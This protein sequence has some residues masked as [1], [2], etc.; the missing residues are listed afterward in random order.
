MGSKS[1][2][3]LPLVAVLGCCVASCGGGNSSSPAPT[4]TVGGTVTGLLSGTSVTLQN[5]AANDTPVSVNASF[6]FSNALAGGTMY[7]VTVLTQP[8]GETCTIAN[9]TGVIA[10]ANVSVAV[11]CVPNNYSVGGTVSGL[12]P[13]VSVTLVNNGGNS[14]TVTANGAFRFST[15]VAAG[16]AYSVSVWADPSGESCTVANG[17]GTV[18][19]ANITGITVSCSVL[20]YTINA[21]V[22]GLVANSNLVLQ[23]NGGDTLTVTSGGSFPFKAAIPS[24]SSYAVTV[25]TQPAGQTCFVIGGSGPVGD[26]NVS[27]SVVCPWHLAYVPDFQ[28]NAVLGYYIDPTSGALMPLQGN[29]IGGPT[30]LSGPTTV[31][32]TPNNK[33]L[34]IAN[35]S[36]SGSVCGYAID[37]V[38]GELTQLPGSPFAAGAAPRTIVIDATGAFLFV[39]NIGIPLANGNPDPLNPSSISGYTI[40]QITGALTPIAGSPYVTSVSPS[41]I[42]ADPIANFLFASNGTYNIDT[43]TGALTYAGSSGMGCSN[44]D[45]NQQNCAS[46]IRP[47]GDFLYVG[48]AAFGIAPTTGD[49]T[50]V[51]GGT[52]PSIS[53]SVAVTPDGK[54]LYSSQGGLISAYSIDATTGLT[55]STGQYVPPDSGLSGAI[56]VDP[57]G[58][59]MYFSIL[60]AAGIVGYSIDSST[61]ALTSLAGSPFTALK[62]P[63]I[64]GSGGYSISIVP[65]L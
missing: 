3:L 27:V 48:A 5:N 32:A 7:A 56:T 50:L 39:A 12:L 22:F 60:G 6:S 21:N 37:Q 51:A 61:G 26:A 64:F 53:N 2:I 45:V 43:S 23:D 42:V 55:S 65:L 15:P 35:Q 33:F 13:G 24:Q 52:A 9:S 20:S 1:R 38:T 11:T 44:S 40:D 29:K 41:P 18:S 46:A 30:C 16:S 36:G 59:F 49:F 4:F 10:S 14:A 28:D 8:A 19:S 17:S 57:S 34:Y 47:A 62:Y 58:Q 31:A 54:F 63:G 25:L